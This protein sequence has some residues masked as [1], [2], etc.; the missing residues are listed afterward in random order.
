MQSTNLTLGFLHTYGLALR[1]ALEQVGGLAILTALMSMFGSLV[2]IWTMQRTT[3]LASLGSATGRLLIIQ[4]LLLAATAISLALNAITPF[5]TPDPP[6]LASLPV[7]LTVTFLLL[8][9]GITYARLETWLET[10][11]REKIQK[12][13]KSSTVVNRTDKNLIH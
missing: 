2:A 10:I 9:F 1:D 12:E 11:T 4:R 3:M 8:V 13:E 5:I 6:W 7:V